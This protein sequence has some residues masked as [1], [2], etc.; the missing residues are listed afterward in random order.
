[1]RKQDRTN[2]FVN[3]LKDY[4]DYTDKKGYHQD[5]EAHREHYSPQNE[6][7]KNEKTKGQKETK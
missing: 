3:Y 1:M 6:T 2:P 7:E 5:S 4:K